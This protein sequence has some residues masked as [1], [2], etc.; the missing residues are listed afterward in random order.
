MIGDPTRRRAEELA[1]FWTPFLVRLFGEAGVFEA[2]GRGAR[3]S[4]EVAG[5]LQLDP[6]VL[7][8]SCRALASRGIFRS[9]G[10]GQVELTEVGRRYLRDEPGNVAG[11]ANFKPYE[12]HAWAEAM[13]TLR[14]GEPSFPVHFGMDFWD[15]LSA[16]PDAGAH[17]SDTMRRRVGSILD[18]AL[19]LY[20]WPDG[21]TIIDVGGGNGLLLERVLTSRP[22]VHAVL[23]DRPDV[24]VEAKGLE[25]DP[26]VRSNI[27][28]EGGDFFGSVPEGGDLYVLASVL[29][30]WDDDASTRILATVRDAMHADARLLLLES[31]LAPDDEPDL[32]KQI[33][34]HMAVLFGARERTR[35]EWTSLLSSSGFQITRTVPTP[36][37]SWIE[38]R[39]DPDGPRFG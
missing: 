32:G 9:R 20:P 37:L 4:E 39:A 7:A 35:E 36:S 28:F 17:F 3:A 11:V 6:D 13:A 12:M 16:H 34:L 33:D 29:H 14:T 19:P 30:D 1:D 23:F 21:G 38:A 15:W 18:G 27:R 26:S 2:F 8:R 22:G 31:I 5:E 10:D 25:W 24:V